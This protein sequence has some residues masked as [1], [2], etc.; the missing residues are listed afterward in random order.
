[1]IRIGA[2]FRF[3]A[4]ASAPALMAAL[5]GVNAALFAEAHGKDAEV[6]LT[7]PAVDLAAPLTRRCQAAVLY[8]TDRDP[9]SDARLVLN[10]MRSGSRAGQEIASVP[11]LPTGQPGRYAATVTLPAYGTWAFAVQV[12]A[13]AEGHVQVEEHILPPWGQ[14]VPA[15]D[16]RARLLLRFGFR[17]AINIAAL[18]VHLLGT[19]GLFAANGA[20]FA[21]GLLQVSDPQYRQRVARLF[22]WAAGG[23]FILLGASGVYNAVYNAPARSPGLLH[24]G[25]LAGLPFGSAYLIAFAAKMVLVAALFVGTSLL[26]ARFRRGLWRS[27]RAASVLVTPQEPIGA[28]SAQPVQRE[29][30]LTL[31]ATNLLAE[32]AVL[33]TAAV[34]GYLHLLTH[35]G[36]FLQR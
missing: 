3:I 5:V 10:A 14:S 28:G 29:A 9:L 17:D 20:V 12:T 6:R 35:A 22:P 1:M 32:S 36:A 26:A 13:P 7:C 19:A 8:A 15:Q 16:A 2:R 30:S 24:P 18:A 21:A 11:L 4:R 27:P 33:L 25:T 34:A 23:S 31:A